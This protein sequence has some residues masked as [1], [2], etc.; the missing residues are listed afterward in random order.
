MATVAEELPGF[1]TELTRLPLLQRIKNI[2]VLDVHPGEW[3][4][5]LQHQLAAGPGW[6]LVGHLP[7][8][9]ILASSHK[10]FQL[11]GKIYKE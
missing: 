11:I 9:A 5:G 1:V 2:R 7:L 6:V 3:V 10:I 4:L 8:T